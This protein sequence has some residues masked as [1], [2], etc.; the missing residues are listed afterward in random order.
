MVQVNEI[1]LKH[2]RMGHINFDNLVK[3]SKTQ[4]VRYI[5]RISKPTN[6]I[7]KPCQHRKQT[8]VSFKNKEYSTSNPL[9]LVHTNLCRKARTQNLKGESYFML[10]IDDYTRMTWVTFLK[11]KPDAFEKFKSFKGLIENETDL[12]IKR[13]RSN[14]GGE[15]TSYEFEEFCENHGIKSHFSSARAP[16][17]NGVVER[18]NK[19]LQEMAKTMLN[20]SKL[21]D[22]FWREAISTTIYILNRVQIRVKIN[23]TP[24]ELWKGRPTAVKYFKVFGIKCYI[25]RNEDNLGKFD[26]RIDEGIFL[27]YSFGSKAY[28]CYNKIFCKVVD[29]FDD[30]G[31]YRWPPTFSN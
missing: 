5:P 18:K 2:R 7:C 11:E 9:E 29:S 25:K 20:E 3:L 8:R 27:G 17:K 22:T 24:Y 12:K 10:L 26:Y 15:F 19:K 6:I 23:E 16:R 28:K 31:G 21:P 13:L 14:K 30:P 1:C 4:V